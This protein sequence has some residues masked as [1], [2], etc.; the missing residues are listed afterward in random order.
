MGNSQSQ[1]TSYETT[2]LVQ[3]GDDGGLVHSPS[4]GGEKVTDLRCVWG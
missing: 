2:A 4:G 3:V 1:E